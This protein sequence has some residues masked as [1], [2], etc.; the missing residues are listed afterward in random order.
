M[1]A[2]KRNTETYT[3]KYETPLGSYKFDFFVCFQLS[4][5]VLYFILFAI[6]F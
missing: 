4:F 3:Y 6:I 1:L 5:K 2:F